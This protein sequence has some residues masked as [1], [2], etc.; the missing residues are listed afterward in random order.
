[1][2]AE[3]VALQA[4][5]DSLT[6]EL[7]DRYEEITLL[8]D[9]AREM[10]VVVDL[11]EASRTA[12]ARSL[13]V[14]PARLGL[15]LIG[16][17]PDALRTVA[18]YG[19]TGTGESRLHI[20]QEAAREALR[21]GAKVMVEA[22][23]TTTGGG[24]HPEPVLVAPLMPAGTSPTEHRAVGVLAFVGHEH[25]DRF[26]AA[27]EQLVAVVAGQLAQGIENA[28]VV[29]QLRE[30]ERLE[31]DLDLAAGI[32]RSLLP[33]SPPPLSGATL[34]AECRP[35]AQVGGDYFDFM[36]DAE[37]GVNIVVADVTGHGLGPGLIMAM[38]RSAL[39]AELR[40]RGSLSEALVAT[41]TVMWDDLVATE[42][43][44]T[45]FAAR[46]EPRAR[47][48]H[49]VNAG[50]QPA[51]LHRADGSTGELSSDGMPL[52]I[53]PAPDYHAS[54]LQLGP[55]DV[56]LM[57]SDGVVEATSPGGLAYGVG[58]L[59]AVIAQ[60]AGSAPELVTQVLADLATFQNSE[61]QRDDIT[62]VA[63]QVSNSNEEAVD[64]D[65]S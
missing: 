42:A 41:N 31:S 39:R 58:R 30:K 56:V 60:Y 63:L 21:S 1:V 16:D 65:T 51:L 37:S 33:T 13:Q 45:V 22:G 57:F 54:T 20:S 43:F 26:S 64:D 25:S 48:L 8:Y 5:V 7:L 9:L 10:G 27:E 53:V 52:G 62:L 15:V 38:T 14:I 23:A 50:H 11:E 59:S 28:R 12:L 17:H 19:S 24:V 40:R 35:A 61:T 55:G 3:L 18:S 36:V 32:Q 44:I 34:A 2:T 46:Y 4:D 47:C 6:G 29:T 49:Y